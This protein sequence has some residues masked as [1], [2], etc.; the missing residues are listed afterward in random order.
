[1]PN[2]KKTILI[3]FLSV[4][5]SF[6]VESEE[7]HNMRLRYFVLLSLTFVLSVLGFVPFRVLSSQQENVIQKSSLPNQWKLPI[8]HAEVPIQP[9]IQ[10]LPKDGSI[11]DAEETDE[12]SIRTATGGIIYTIMISL[13]VIAFIG[14]GAF[15]VYVFFLSK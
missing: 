10:E 15:L 12:Q 13:T 5:R 2:Y 14:N 8:T 6:Q 7:N 11:P 4:V 3:F 9:P 1:V